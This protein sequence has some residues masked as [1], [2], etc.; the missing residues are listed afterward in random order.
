M[1]EQEKINGWTF[2]ETVKN[3]EVIMDIE[4]N[5]LKWD[6]LRHLRD[7]AETFKEELEQYRALGL[8]PELIEAMQGHNIAMINDLAEYQALGTVEELR[9]ARD[10]QIEFCEWEYDELEEQWQ[11]DCNV[12]FTIHDSD[13][14]ITNY[15]PCCGK[16][17]KVRCEDDI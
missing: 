11:T 9:V 1:T 4:E 10:K 6:T 13:R 7:F 15:C 17:I 3:T 8:T 14:E 16:R 5:I 2:E 12:L